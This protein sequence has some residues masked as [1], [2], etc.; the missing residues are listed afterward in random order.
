MNLAD[1]QPPAIDV[2]LSPEHQ[3][4][5]PSASADGVSFPAL[6]KFAFI[7]ATS[8]VALGTASPGS[9]AIDVTKFQ[10]LK[11][12]LPSASQAKATTTAERYARL[13]QE[14]VA[15]GIPLL[16]DEELREEIRSRKGVKREPED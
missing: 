16:N 1:N 4:R 10:G 2:F 3:Y 12:V 14:I 9:E 7:I 6:P 15:A 11:I 8:I 13:K 5:E